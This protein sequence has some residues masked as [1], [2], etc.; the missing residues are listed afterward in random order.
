MLELDH[1]IVFL[2][3]A[4][5]V[6]ELDLAGLVLDEGTRHVGQG[7]RNR[8][9]VFADSY[10]ELLWVDAPAEARASGLLFE[11]R[12]RGD[13]CPIGVVLR[14]RRP[15]HVDSIPYTVPAGPVLHV[16]DD[17]L[18]PFLAIH[19]AVDLDPLRPVHRMAPEHV[20]RATA[21]THAV[22]TCD[23]PP[24]DLAVPGLSSTRGRPGLSISLG[25]RDEP[26]RVGP[27]A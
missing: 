4:G 3:R 14:G 11:E 23:G 8:R 24:W 5:A 27:T 16:V 25:G 22:L 20:N 10:V 15:E 6:D 7:T 17:P 9:I 12:C 19:E 13:A 21:I 18:R 2:D 1:L 26:W